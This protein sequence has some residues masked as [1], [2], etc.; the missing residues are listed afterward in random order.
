MKAN[1][2]GFEPV[3]NRICS[4]R[5]RMPFFNIAIINIYAP[6]EEKDEEIKETFYQ[7]LEQIY[8]RLLSNDVKIIVGDAN[9][10][11]VSNNNGERLIDFASSNNMRIISTYFPHKN[12]HKGT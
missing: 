12:I 9:A 1:I 10:K 3:N 2:L 11:I 6:T 4:L 7:D 8:D 5:I